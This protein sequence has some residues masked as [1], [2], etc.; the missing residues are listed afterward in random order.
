MAEQPHR[1]YYPWVPLGLAICL[2]A[3]VVALFLISPGGPRAAAG[4]PTLEGPA[5]FQTTDALRVSV[6]LSSPEGKPLKG[7]LRADLVADNTVVSSK[8]LTVAQSDPAESYRFDF[9]QQ[10][11]PLKELKV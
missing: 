5:G 1:W 7:E 4:E 2:V 6:S 3:G 11:R 10:K 8:S 9:P